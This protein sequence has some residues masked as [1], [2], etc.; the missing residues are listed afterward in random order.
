MDQQYIY[1]VFS[2]TPY[3]TGKLIR[4][5]TKETYNHVSISLDRE[6]TKMY[7]FSRRYYRT[8]LYGGFVHE[9]RSRYKFNEQPTQICLCA[10]PITEAQYNEIT[11]L[12]EKMHQ[13]NSF[14]IYN[15]LS[16]LGAVVHRPIRTKDA[17]TC[18]EFCVKVLQD[19]GV[20]VQQGK[21][22]TVG[23]VQHILAPYVVYTGTMP[24]PDIYDKEYYAEKPVAHP[25]LTTLRDML[26]LFPRLK[27]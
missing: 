19:L 27:T 7:S 18:V 17:Y 2:S 13:E 23:D 9:T 10:L 4:R 8:P 24:E 6:L 5:F 14:Y 21:Y 15:H 20:D 12:L 22:Y 25:T 26:K 11:Q 16:L 3:T 1:I